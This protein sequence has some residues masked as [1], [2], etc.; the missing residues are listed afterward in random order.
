MER[1]SLEHSIILGILE[2]KD[3]ICYEFVLCQEKQ[4]PRIHFIRMPCF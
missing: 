2:I 3:P 4:G 1:R